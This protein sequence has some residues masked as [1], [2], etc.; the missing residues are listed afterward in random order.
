M[1]QAPTGCKP[2]R[3]PHSMHLP[4]QITV[5]RQ[6]RVGVML[7]LGFASGL[8]LALTS[9]TLQAWLTLEGAD[10]R[11]VGLFTLAGLPYALKFLWAPL[12]DRFRLPWLDRRRGWIVLTQLG[13]VTGLGCMAML[14]PRQMP[15]LVGAVAFAVVFLSASQDIV[16]DAYRAD[17]LHAR[18]RGAGAGVFVSGY[19]IAMLVSGG[20]AL[21]LADHI[22]WRQTYLLMAALMA[23]GLIG[24][25]LA[26]HPDSEAAPPDSVA[27]AYRLPLA[28][29][30]RRPGALGILF[31]IVLYKL[32][33][34][35][36]GTLTT[37]F[38]IGDAGFSPT[39]VGAIS[40]GAG[41]FALLF[42]ALAGG[43]LMTGLGLVRALLWFGALQAVSNLM[44]MLL[45]WAGHD[46]TVM[47]SAVIIENLAGG[48]GTAA[49]VALLMALCDHRYTATQYAIFSAFAA[50]GRIFAGPAAG[51]LVH[52]MGWASFFLLTFFIALPGLV[53]VWW[54]RERIQAVDA[55]QA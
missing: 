22:G 10:I 43:A 26:P 24:V 36:A 54:L 55:L 38:L 39:D 13:L 25:W 18:E 17:V 35:F 45:A 40:K 16:A 28:E 5:Y 42:G 6:R 30:A 19:R 21:V 12:L 8:P 27:G 3:D 46:Y 20:L 31:L 51:V 7:L 41:L 53:A 37:A 33:D 48:M 32:G 52:A 9:G 49:F 15:W 14:S 4:E 23:S 44:F 34:A 50:L 2:P 11:L 1:Q 29:F 47:V